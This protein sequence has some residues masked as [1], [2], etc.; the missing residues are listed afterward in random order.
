MMMWLV[1]QIVFCCQKLWQ[2]TSS[3]KR[4]FIWLEVAQ[5]GIV[6]GGAV[7]VLLTSRADPPAARLA[8][9]ASAA[10]AR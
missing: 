8:S 3:I 4:L 9:I 10:V 2:E 6:V 1:R 5:L 7:P